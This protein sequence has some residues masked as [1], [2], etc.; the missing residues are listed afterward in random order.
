MGNDDWGFIAALLLGLGG[1]AL[2]AGGTIN[3]PVCQKRI[4]KNVQFCPHCQTPLSW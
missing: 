1:L 2:L 3:C 4:L